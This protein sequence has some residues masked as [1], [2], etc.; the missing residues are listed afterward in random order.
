MFHFKSFDVSENADMSTQKES[1]RTGILRTDQKSDSCTWFPSQHTEYK[2]KKTK[3]MLKKMLKYLH[4]SEEPRIQLSGTVPDWRAWDCAWSLVQKKAEQSTLQLVHFAV[5]QQALCAYNVK[6][7]LGLP[8][9]APVVST[10]S[11]SVWLGESHPIYK[12]NMLWQ[13]FL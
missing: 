11:P 4:H 12:N 13:W 1:L 3:T 6:F 2:T 9:T 10:R 7:G 8:T 5:S